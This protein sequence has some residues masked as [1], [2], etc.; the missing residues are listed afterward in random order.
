MPCRCCWASGTATCGR[1]TQRTC[2]R[3]SSRSA[4]ALRC[5][6]WCFGGSK[7][8]LS[9]CPGGFILMMRYL[10]S[11]L[12][13]ALLVPAMLDAQAPAGWKTRIDRSTEASDPDAAGD[14]KFTKAGASGFHAVNPQAAVYWNPANT[15][16]GNYSLKATFTLLEPSNH[17]NYYG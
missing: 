16:T 15:A 9:Y 17:N 7:L 12:V 5:R 4:C 8:T 14:V 13:L 6:R 10:T 1:S 11:V 3:S 2:W